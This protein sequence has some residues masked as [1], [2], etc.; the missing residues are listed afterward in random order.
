M[1]LTNT[2]NFRRKFG[3]NLVLATALGLIMALYSA[4]V[5]VGASPSDSASLVPAGRLFASNCSQCHGTDGQ[6]G[7][8]DQL[9]GDPALDTFNKLKDQQL[10]NTIMGAQARGYTDDQ[11]RAIAAYFATVVKK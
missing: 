11:L 3:P 1:K 9:A 4:F 6:S 5:P 10:K 8:I 7:A 2:R